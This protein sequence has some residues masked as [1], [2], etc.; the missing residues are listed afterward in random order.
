VIREEWLFLAGVVLIVAMVTIVYRHKPAA[1]RH[2]R[3]CVKMLCFC[4]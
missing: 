1:E 2:P 3:V 4:R